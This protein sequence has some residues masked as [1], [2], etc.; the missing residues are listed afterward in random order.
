MQSR[1]ALLTPDNELLPDKEAA[2]VL[3]ITNSK[4]LSNW[5][6]EGKHPDLPFVR[7]GRSIRYR[8]GDL[9]DF[10]VRHTVGGTSGARNAFP[11]PREALD[12]TDRAAHSTR[13]ADQ[14]VRPTDLLR[15]QS[16]K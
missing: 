16:T 8:L 5:R 1:S 13:S 10:R 14:V 15:K 3:G 6:S 9:L 11:A 7:I 4:T 12:A 2:P